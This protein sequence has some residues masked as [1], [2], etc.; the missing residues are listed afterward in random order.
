M[1]ITLTPDQE[2]WLQAHVE[3]G[4]FAAAKGLHPSESLAAGQK[5]PGDDLAIASAHGR[6]GQA[7]NL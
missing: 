7:T 4:G 5:A 6:E 2:A 1:P 3:T